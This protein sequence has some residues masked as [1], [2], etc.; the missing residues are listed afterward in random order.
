M[1]EGVEGG[2]VWEVVGEIGAGGVVVGG[3]RSGAFFLYM[4]RRKL[5]DYGICV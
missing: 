2:G 1:E 5:E 3:E 4:V